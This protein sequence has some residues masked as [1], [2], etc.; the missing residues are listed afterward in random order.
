MLKF[1][2]K[3]FSY[4]AI[5]NPAIAQLGGTKSEPNWYVL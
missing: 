3:F 2:K 5:Q 1:Y 4:P